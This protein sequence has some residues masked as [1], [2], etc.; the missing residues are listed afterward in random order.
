MPERAARLEAET[1]LAAA[2][3]A[4]SL[5]GDS[6]EALPQAFARVPADALLP[7]VTTTWALSRSRRRT[8]PPTLPAPP[9][10]G[11]GRPGG[12]VGVGGGGR[13]RAGDTGT[14]RSPRLGPRHRSG[15]ARRAGLRAEALGRCWSGG[16]PLAWLADS[17]P[18]ASRG[19]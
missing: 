2:A 14:R 11:G 1:A 10:R 6:V 4:L 7:V 3:R 15:G 16:R 17:R 12:G 13:R 19:K 9:R 18:S 5:K 8:G